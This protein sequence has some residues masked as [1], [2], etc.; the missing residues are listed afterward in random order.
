MTTAALL[1]VFVLVPVITLGAV[2]GDIIS[3]VAQRQRDKQAKCQATP[4]QWAGEAA[5]RAVAAA[6][7]EAQ[8]AAAEELA[9][10]ERWRQ[11][12]A[13][14]RTLEALLEMY[15]DDFARFVAQLLVASGYREVEEH[16][17][18]TGDQEGVDLHATAPDGRSVLVQCALCWPRN[19]I[20]APVLQQFLG[21]LVQHGADLGVFVTTS[22]FTPQAQTAAQVHP[23][24]LI[25]GTE[26][27]Q[28]VHNVHARRAGAA[29][30]SLSP[31][32]PMPPAPPALPSA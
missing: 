11:E 6:R 18:T 17:G 31:R 28:W 13:A 30:I 22:A 2:A 15:P 23:V 8:Q 4:T 3:W 27:V 26:L 10:E 21:T 9:A 25:N 7:A 12:V 32:P 14:R 19:A 20:G 5:P 29:A 1:I 24:W 16:G